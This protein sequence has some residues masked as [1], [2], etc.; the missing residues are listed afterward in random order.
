MY[1]QTAVAAPGPGGKPIH[2]DPLHPAR[3]PFHLADKKSIVA[4]TPAVTGTPTPGNASHPFLLFRASKRDESYPVERHDAL[5]DFFRDSF[6]NSLLT[7][8]SNGPR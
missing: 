7:A 6:S 3:R 1:R 4:P 2:S 5:V 8:A